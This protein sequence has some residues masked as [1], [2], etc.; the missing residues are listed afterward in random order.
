MFKKYI[1]VIKAVWRVSAAKGDGECG[2]K[3]KQE[4]TSYAVPLPA[5]N[6]L[7]DEKFEI[8]A[9]LT[10]EILKLRQRA[11][12]AE[13][14]IRTYEEELDEAAEVFA[15]IERRL[16]SSEFTVA[17]KIDYCQE[18]ALNAWRDIT[19]RDGDKPKDGLL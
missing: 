4:P 6:K 11:V 12:A 19:N 13:A 15:R 14:I 17:D 9:K 5:W 10:A 18:L 8:K 2:V 16:S 3:I 7:V 1:D